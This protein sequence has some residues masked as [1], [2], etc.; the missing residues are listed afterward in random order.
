M[1]PQ[2]LSPEVLAQLQ[3]YVDN[4]DVDSYSEM[5]RTLAS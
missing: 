1:D 2:T 5:R 4:G 3:V